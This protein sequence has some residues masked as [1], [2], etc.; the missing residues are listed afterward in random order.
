MPIM[1]L[2]AMKAFNSA[3]LTPWKKVMRLGF[4]FYSFWQAYLLVSFTINSHRS[5]PMKTKKYISFIM[6][7]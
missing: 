2:I 1:T 5:S 7:I 4:F 6:I 3:R